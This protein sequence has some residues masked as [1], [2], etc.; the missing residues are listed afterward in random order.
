MH[1]LTMKWPQSLPSASGAGVS[2]TKQCRVGSRDARSQQGHPTRTNKNQNMAE[3]I[4]TAMTPGPPSN[5]GWQTGSTA[6]PPSDG[7]QTAELTNIMALRRQLWASGYPP[8]AVY[9]WNARGPSPGKRPFGREWQ[10]RARLDPA[11]AAV[12]N[13]DG[14]ALNTG[15]LCDGLRAI[16]IDVDD[17]AIA[18]RVD[19]LT[20]ERLGPAPCGAEPTARGV[21][22][23][24]VRL[25][26][27]RASA[28]SR[29][30]AAKFSPWAW[31]TVR[32]LRDAPRW[33]ALSMTSG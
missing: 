25:K 16:D 20:V 21:C 28:R 24:T 13:P 17:P 23:C 33:A 3:Q 2:I 18:D 5:G 7:W 31:S 10:N 8:V 6:G 26:G 22:A 30:R 27:S 12:A 29:E 19:R 9:N 4:G 1:Q 15:I 11:E 14:R 32:R